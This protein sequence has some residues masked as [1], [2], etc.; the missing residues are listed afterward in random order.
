MG[1]K[2]IEKKQRV[3]FFDFPGHP[4]VHDLTKKLS[5]S[6]DLEIYH[7]YNPEQLGP[8]SDFKTNEQEIIVEVPQKISRNFYI[9]F[10]NEIQYVF[11]CYKQILKIKPTIMVCSS[12][13]LVPMFFISFLKKIFSIKIIFWIQ[14]V[15]YIAI[16]RILK[17]YKNPLLT[18]I[19][20]LFQKLE[21]FSVK[22]SDALI[23]ITEDFKQF[24]RNEIEDKRVF[25]INNWGSL[26]NIKPMNKKNNFS[27]KNNISNS[28]NILYSGTLGYKHNPDVIVSLAKTLKEK[29]ENVRLIIV[30]EGPVVEYLM[31][32]SNKFNLDNII[33]LPFQDFELFPQVLASSELSLVLLEDD[34]SDFCVPSKF[35]S[36]LCAERIPIVNISKKNL[37]SKIIYDNRCGVVVE[38]KFDLNDKV[39]NIIQ[40][41]DDYKHLGEN[42]YK[43]AKDNFDIDIISKKFIKILAEID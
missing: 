9:R 10:F 26:E 28:F 40:N 42:G 43:Y 23:L 6:K 5:K 30:S 13:P 20:Y 15:Q 3:I 38:N 35:L 12:I 8:K 37:V 34:S 17:R 1:R 7:L 14:D 31:K 18:Y 33:F 36:I 4:F 41:F 11:K 22:S 19:S 27:I 25:I 21:T 39:E 29:F 16:N 2:I 32:E 24:F